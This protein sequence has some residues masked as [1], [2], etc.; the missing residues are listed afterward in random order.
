VL[1][2]PQYVTLAKKSMGEFK[3]MLCHPQER[4]YSL[5]EI[6][7]L[8]ENLGLEFLGFMLDDDAEIR[9]EFAARFP[10]DKEMDNI[11]SFFSV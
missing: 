1:S 11:L 10:H 4:I 2:A 9:K 5:P 8:L 3:D 6:G 7:A